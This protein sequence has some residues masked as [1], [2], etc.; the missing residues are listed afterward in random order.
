M[1]HFVN[2]LKKY[3]VFEGRNTRTEYWMFVL[4]YSVIYIGLMLI[5]IFLRTGWLAVIF[6]ILILVPSLSCG[7]RRLH[8][9]SR[10][11]WWQ[12]IY[13]VPLIGLIVM[14]VFLAQDSHGDNQYG[15]DPRTV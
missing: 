9:T 13:L 10:S 12:L 15:P 7:A 5:D 3:A 2:A 14:I 8:D 1:E 4:I 6:S 11:G